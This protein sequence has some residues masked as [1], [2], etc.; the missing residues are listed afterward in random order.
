MMA[1]KNELKSFHPFLSSGRD[2]LDSVFIHYKF[3]IIL[4]ENGTGAF[5]LGIFKQMNSNDLMVIWPLKLLF[6][7]AISIVIWP[8]K[9]NCYSY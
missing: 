8:L 1:S 5:F 4:K 2:C 9:L 3:G 6:H 7:M